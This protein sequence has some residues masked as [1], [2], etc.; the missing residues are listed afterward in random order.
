MKRHP[1]LH[2]LSRDHHH[3]LVQAR[4]LSLAAGDTDADA[5]RRAAEHFADFWKSDLQAHFLQEEQFVLQLLSPDSLEVRETLRQ[6]NDIRRLVDEF[7]DNL[8]RRQRIEASLLDALGEALRL[9][10][11]FEENELFPALE[12]SASEEELRRMNEQLE[13]TRSQS[14]HGGCALSPTPQATEAGQ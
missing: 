7:G 1:S 9:H 6:H 2:P 4:K 12:S 5:L 14:G 13:V 3:A 8:A 11:H 10:I